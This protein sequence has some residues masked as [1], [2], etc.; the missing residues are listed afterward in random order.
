MKIQYKIYSGGGFECC[1]NTCPFKG[2]CAIHTSAGEFREEDGFTPEL[3][4]VRTTPDHNAS[5]HCVTC[6]Q[7]PVDPITKTDRIFPQGI[8]KLG[9]GSVKEKHIETADISYVQDR[10]QFVK[11]QSEPKS[12]SEVVKIPPVVRRSRPT[13]VDYSSFPFADSHPGV[14]KSCT[15]SNVFTRDQAVAAYRAKVLE[16]IYRLIKQISENGEP[17]CII[18]YELVK[19]RLTDLPTITD[20]LEKNGYS[21]AVDKDGN[22]KVSWTHIVGDNEHRPI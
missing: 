13:D 15:M 11:N 12:K 2:E 20:S 1:E 7:K 14:G 6:H 21:V 5:Y 22:I 9:V 18:T 4:K 10:V 16:N 19:Y 3:Y 8:S 17:D